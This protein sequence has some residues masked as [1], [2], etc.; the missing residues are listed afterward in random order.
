M[1]TVELSH[2]RRNGGPCNGSSISPPPVAICEYKIFPKGFQKE[3][4]ANIQQ[5]AQNRQ[6]M[7]IFFFCLGPQRPKVVE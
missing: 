3:Y 4:K 7:G 2:W 5:Q 1:A 6:Q